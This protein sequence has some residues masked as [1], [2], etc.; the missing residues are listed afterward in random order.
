MARAM[1]RANVAGLLPVV[2]A[3]CA[4]PRSP[5]LSLAVGETWSDGFEEG[6]SGWAVGRDLLSDSNADGPVHATVE[7]S[8]L[9]ASEGRGS[10][11]FQLDGRQDDGTV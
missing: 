5:G 11:R 1:H 8:M 10:A 6:L 4:T 3:G 7:D 2:V 9:R